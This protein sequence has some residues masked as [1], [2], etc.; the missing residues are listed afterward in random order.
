MIYNQLRNPIVEPSVAASYDEDQNDEYPPPNV[1]HVPYGFVEVFGQ[2]VSR[3]FSQETSEPDYIY[4]FITKDSGLASMSSVTTSQFNCDFSYGDEI[5]GLGVRGA[6]ISTQLISKGVFVP[7]SAADDNM[8]LRDSLR[9][10]FDF[11]TRLSP[12][13]SY[14]KGLSGIDISNPSWEQESFRLMQIPSIFYGESI[15]KGTVKLD[16]YNRGILVGTLQDIRQN[17][18]LLVTYSKYA[19]EVG[20]FVGL[21]FYGEGFLVLTNRSSIYSNSLGHP[22]KITGDLDDTDVTWIDFMKPLENYTLEKINLEENDYAINGS[23]YFDPPENEELP[24]NRSSASY[25]FNTYF[26]GTHSIPTM[27]ML[28]HIEKPEGTHSNNPSFLDSDMQYDDLKL[29]RTADGAAFTPI[30]VGPAPSGVDTMQIFLEESHGLELNGALSKIKISNLLYQGVDAFEGID[31]VCQ[32]DGEKNLKIYRV[33][34]DGSHQAITTHIQGELISTLDPPS[35]STRV[36]VL[37]NGY[38]RNRPH[39]GPYG[40]FESDQFRIKNTVKSPFSDPYAEFED[41]T[42]ISKIGIYDDDRNLVGIAKLATPIKK[43]PSRSY[44]FKLKIDL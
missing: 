16:W 4:P 17:G 33:M 2:N 20:K 42:Y 15:E 22:D 1:D 26:K 11:Y 21:V 41:H 10:T 40:Y 23:Y 39:S 43:T 37:K 28:A 12:R 8:R 6:T 36:S 3:P 34:E 9:T 44:T 27:T 18:E 25:S 14:L 5:K 32:P 35:F 24:D 7:G 29:R 38:Q 30:D 13:F 19:S 31:L